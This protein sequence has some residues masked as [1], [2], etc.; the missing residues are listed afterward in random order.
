MWDEILGGL[1]IGLAAALL[2]LGAGR[3]SGISGVL[4]GVFQFRKPGQYWSWAFLLGLLLAW[5]FVQLMHYPISITVSDEPLLLV[6]AGLL[7]GFGTYIGNGCTSGH[8]V[9]GMGRL[10]LRST[11]ATVTFMLAGVI[12][13]AVMRIMG[14]Q[15]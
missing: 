9:C 5:P 8:G 10:S 13:V 7:V 6:S 14:V 2:W 11:V 1:L 12:T 3:I 4:S 15:V